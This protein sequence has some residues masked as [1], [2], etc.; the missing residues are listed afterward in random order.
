M[1]MRNAK[2]TY[3]GNENSSEISNSHS[4]DDEIEIVGANPFSNHMR[5][6]KSPAPPLER[7]K[8]VTGNTG[9]FGK[10]N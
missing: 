5:V 4:S 6:A 1:V 7:P 9:K 2:N 10:M 8:T 3:F